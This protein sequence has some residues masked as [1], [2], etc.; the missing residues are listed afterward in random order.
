MRNNGQDPSEGS[1]TTPEKDESK[2]IDDSKTVIDNAKKDFE[3]TGG[4]TLAKTAMY[5]C[6][7]GQYEA[8]GSLY[9]L[10]NA[11]K[12]V[13]GEVITSEK[14]KKLTSISVSSVVFILDRMSTLAECADWMAGKRT[15]D[16]VKLAKGADKIAGIIKTYKVI[17]TCG[18]DLTKGG[19][20]LWN[21]TG[22]LIGDIQSYYESKDRL[23]KQRDNY[24][25]NTPVPE[26]DKERGQNAC[27]AKYGMF[28]YKQSFY[29]YPY[30]SSKCGDY[31]GNSGTAA[32]YMK[33]N[34]KSIYT[35][36]DDLKWCSA[37]ATGKMDFDG[38]RA[39]AVYC[40]DQDSTCADD[41]MKRAG[42]N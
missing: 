35:R 11:A 36:E 37:N 41:A 42:F 16:M 12:G 32:K 40:C 20:I 10:A 25:D 4:K 26:Q 33:D 17:A 28:L 2:V 9:E 30:R 39:C 22:C 13:N 21:N 5:R 3:K 31:C 38:V 19:V 7:S 34:L 23:N 29:S 27:M 18:V 8:V 14:L 15:K 24:V 6:L 1:S